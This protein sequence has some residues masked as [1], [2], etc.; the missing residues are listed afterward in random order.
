MTSAKRNAPGV[1][2]GGEGI[3]METLLATAITNEHSV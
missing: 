1:S 3:V 2:R